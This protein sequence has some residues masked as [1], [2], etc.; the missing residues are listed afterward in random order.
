MLD[1]QKDTIEESD[2]GKK[3][4]E[5]FAITLLAPGSYTRYDEETDT[6]YFVF[7]PASISSFVIEMRD[8]IGMVVN[9]HT[10]EV[11]GFQVEGW[12]K[13]AKRYELAPFIVWP[14]C[15]FGSS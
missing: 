4:Q 10:G 11:A 14:L 13:Y 8:G 7:G 9:I 6:K 2:M 1:N 3:I 15:T 12:S 5:H